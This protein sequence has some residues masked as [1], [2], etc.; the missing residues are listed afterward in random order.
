MRSLPSNRHELQPEPNGSKIYVITRGNV[1]T[2]VGTN[3]INHDLSPLACAATGTLSVACTLHLLGID[4]A[5][6]AN[7]VGIASALALLVTY[8]KRREEFIA[9]F[10]S[11]RGLLKL[12]LGG[13]AASLILGDYL[14]AHND[15]AV[16][17]VGATFTL[18]ILAE[19]MRENILSQ[20]TRSK[21]QA[22][23]SGEEDGD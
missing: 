2:L 18:G 15:L 7:G 4:S 9:L 3:A 17:I 14:L 19:A 22:L 20:L 6:V 8:R 16:Y 5:Y 11:E 13:G 21:P 10:R 12:V 23:Q 1:T